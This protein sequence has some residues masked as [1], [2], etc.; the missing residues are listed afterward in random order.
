MITG[1][2]TERAFNDYVDRILDAKRVFT[3]CCHVE[4]GDEEGA[5]RC[6]ACGEGCL[7]GKDE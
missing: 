7:I 3:N 1:N 5:G 4:M 2:S 6:P